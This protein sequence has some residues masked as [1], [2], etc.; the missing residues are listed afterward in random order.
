MFAIQTT[1]QIENAMK[2]NMTQLSASGANVVDAAEDEPQTVE[3]H[4]RALYR[5]MATLIADWR[6]CSRPI[7]RR[8]R[9]C[10]P[11]AQGCRSP[12]QSNRQPMTK[13]REAR[14]RALLKHAIEREL[15]LRATLGVEVSAGRA[16]SGK[17][18]PGFPSRRRGGRS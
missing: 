7:C 5:K 8:K 11:P 14:E 6:R 13:E 3:Q 15:A 12:R 4:R 16:A 9:A 18:R 17:P 10:E 2:R 1:P